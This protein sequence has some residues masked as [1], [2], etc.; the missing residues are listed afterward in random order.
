MVIY[1]PSNVTENMSQVCSPATIQNR[2]K[3]VRSIITHDEDEVPRLR[4]KKH[5]VR[6]NHQPRVQHDWVEKMAPCTDHQR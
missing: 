2:H 4:R 6:E 1:C 3:I 5:L